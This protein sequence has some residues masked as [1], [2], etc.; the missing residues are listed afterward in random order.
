MIIFA[1]LKKKCYRGL[2][3][4][5]ALNLLYCS[6]R[7][8]AAK[9]TC[10]HTIYCNLPAVHHCDVTSTTRFVLSVPQTQPISVFMSFSSHRRRAQQKF[11]IE[12][13]SSHSVRRAIG[14][15]PQAHPTNLRPL[16]CLPLAKPH[17]T[18]CCGLCKV[19]STRMSEWL[20]ERLSGGVCVRVCG[21]PERRPS[22]GECCIS[23]MCILHLT[24]W[25]FMV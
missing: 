22:C 19:K 18:F 6:R 14:R 13:S 11:R 25:E 8:V 5:C 9:L 1:T 15:Q 4:R 2:L 16:P 7:M 21:P 24:A 17:K 12:F 20:S 3:H 23:P 10:I